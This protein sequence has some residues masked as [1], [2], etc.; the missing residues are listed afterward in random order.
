MSLTRELLDF[1]K[2]VVDL[3][4]GLDNHIRYLYRELEW[5]PDEEVISFEVYSEITDRV[6]A[7]VSRMKDYCRKSAG[8]LILR[9]VEVSKRCIEVE[10]EFLRKQ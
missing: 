10:N 1:E 6:E 7:E 9:A 8:D 4:D 3:K 2:A 5:D